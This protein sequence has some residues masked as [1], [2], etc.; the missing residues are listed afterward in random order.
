MG[1]TEELRDL[2][3]PKR[4]GLGTIGRSIALRSNFLP[5][6]SLPSGTVSVYELVIS[7]LVPVAKNRAIYQIWED[8]CFSAG[9]LGTTRPVYDGRKALYAP[10]PIPMLEGSVSEQG[11]I[12]EEHIF[13]VNYYEDGL[14][15]LK[16]PSTLDRAPP[17][18]YQLSLR[19]VKGI[20]MDVLPAFLAGLV[21]ETP[22][23][24]INVI[25]VL[26]RHRPSLMY[27]TIGRCFYT[28]DTALEIA[29]GVELWQ[30]FH[31]SV[32]PASGAMLINLDVSATAFYQPGE[33]NCYVRLYKYPLLTALHKRPS[34][35]SDCANP[36]TTVSQGTHVRKGPQ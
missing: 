26:L 28:Q 24:T 1:D 15:G 21:Q 18:Q 17:R 34:Y 32:K 4:P 20:D 36:W 23:E 9:S 16:D 2:P 19:K 35:R 3:P 22:S 6:Q 29:Q 30:G 13:L 27:T 11:E 14:N 8:E 12:L 31:Q 33:I 7:P 25:D 10:R 5:L